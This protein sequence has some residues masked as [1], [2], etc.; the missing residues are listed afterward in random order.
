MKNLEEQVAERKETRWFDI[1][2]QEYPD[3]EVPRAQVTLK[4]EIWIGDRRPPALF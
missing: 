1:G 3:G 4:I 2:S